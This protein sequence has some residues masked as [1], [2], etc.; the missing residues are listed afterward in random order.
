MQSGTQ[1]TVYN[2][3]LASWYTH[4]KASA[5]KLIEAGAVPHRANHL[6]TEEAVEPKRE[7]NE[8][9]HLREQHG[10]WHTAGLKNDSS[11]IQQLPLELHSLI[12][13]QLLRAAYPRG[14]IDVNDVRK[15]LPPP[16]FRTTRQLRRVAIWR[17]LQ[18][19]LLDSYLILKY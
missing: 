13:D 3:I 16:V 18:V 11:K 2:K 6:R 15:S 19:R 10:R 7:H 14:I 9:V 12:V 4:N 5:R 1:N 17:A 8:K